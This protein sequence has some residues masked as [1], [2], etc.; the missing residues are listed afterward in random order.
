MRLASGALVSGTHRAYVARSPNIVWSMLAKLLK[1]RRSFIWRPAVPAGR[2][3]Y[4]VGDIHGCAAELDCLLKLIEAD[5]AMRDEA[6]TTLI[7]IGDLVD[8]GPAS[9]QVVDR[10]LRLARE[11]RDVRFL[12]GNHEEIF[13]RALEGDQ[14]ALRLFC[15]IGGRETALSYG[16]G[17]AE[18][19]RLDYEQLAATLDRHVPPEHRAFLERL[20]DMIVLGDYVFVHAGVHPHADMEEQEPADLRWIRSPFLDH[21][22]PLAKMV[23]HGHT[24]T[25]DL[26]VQ[27]HRIGIDTGAYATGR[28]TAIGLEGEE[29]W[30]LQT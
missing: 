19:E 24:I 15:R 21:G 13:A 7:F 25:E 11:R 30:R 16:I 5:E 26:D 6:E 3:V 28:L 27:P 14:K 29:I 22:R 20:E 4:A 23:V 18:Y 8:R 1:S 12:A 9:A 10:L 17:A 2:R